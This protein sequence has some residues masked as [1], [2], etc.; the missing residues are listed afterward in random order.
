VKLYSADV[1]R[2]KYTAVGFPNFNNGDGVAKPMA[3]MQGDQALGEWELNT[4]ENMK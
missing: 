2:E 3:C 4:L 1:Q